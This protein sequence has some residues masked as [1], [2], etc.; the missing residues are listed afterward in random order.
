[1]RRAAVGFALGAFFAL[2][3]VFGVRLELRD[4]AV[5]A[6]VEVECD[7]FDEMDTS[8]GRVAV[9]VKTSAIV[10]REC[11]GAVVVLFGGGIGSGW[12]GDESVRSRVSTSSSA[13]V[14]RNCGG[15]G[16]GSVAS[17]TEAAFLRDL[18]LVGD[19]V[20]DRHASNVVCLLFPRDEAIE[21]PCVGRAV[22]T[23]FVTRVRGF[24]AGS[25]EGEGITG[26]SARFK[27]SIVSREGISDSVAGSEGRVRER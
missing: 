5:E 23:G 12:M 27:T 22:R 9:A 16:I 10:R 8:G 24:F 13:G 21:A 6:L 18:G 19:A 3:F 4:D 7:A 2:V 11:V 15:A 1:M 26:E 25:C 20:G 14:V 17:K